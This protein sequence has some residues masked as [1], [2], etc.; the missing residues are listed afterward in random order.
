[1]FAVCDLSQDLDQLVADFLFCFPV[2]GFAD[3]R[4]RLGIIAERVAPFPAPVCTLKNGTFS[5]GSSFGRHLTSLSTDSYDRSATSVLII[6]LLRFKA[7]DFFQGFLF[8]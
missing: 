8:F 3:G 1:M 6:T 4:A 2:D 5:V 7:I